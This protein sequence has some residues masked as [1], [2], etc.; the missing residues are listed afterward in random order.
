MPKPLDNLEFIDAVGK[1]AH[2]V[3][4]D[5]WETKTQVA[6]NDGVWTTEIQHRVLKEIEDLSSSVSM[7]CHALSRIV[8]MNELKT[9]DPDK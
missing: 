6:E 1:E 4:L 2:Q 3:Y 8:K 7:L 5:N 9:I